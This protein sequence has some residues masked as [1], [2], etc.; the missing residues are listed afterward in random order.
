MAEHKWTLMIRKI[1]VNKGKLKGYEVDSDKQQDL[2]TPK[3]NYKIRPDIIWKKDGKI[4]AIFE[5]DTGAYGIY[6]KTIFG[7]MLT[8]ILMA[9]KYNCKFVEVV[10]RDSRKEADNS[11]KAEKIASLFKSQFKSPNIYVLPITIDHTKKYGTKNIQKQITSRLK[12]F[13]II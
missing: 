6:P 11:Y 10:R 1:L 7:S 3:D 5:I 13:K 8:G 12:E 4:K 9:K 2:K